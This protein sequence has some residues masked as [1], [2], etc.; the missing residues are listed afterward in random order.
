MLWLASQRGQVPEGLVDTP[1]LLV[2]EDEQSEV[3]R[4]LQ[5]SSEAIRG[6]QRPSEAIREAVSGGVR[7]HQRTWLRVLN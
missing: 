3:I 2:E 1:A 4:G 5:G 6:H 7:G